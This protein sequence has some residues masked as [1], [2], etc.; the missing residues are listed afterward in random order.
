MDSHNKIITQVANN[1][2]SP[3]GFFQKGKS[4]TWLYDCGYCFVQVEFQ[5]SAYSRGSFCNVGIAFLFEYFGGLNETLAFDYGRERILV[6]NIQFVEYN[7]DDEIFEKQ[8]FQLAQ[9][10]LEYAEN[11]KRFKSLK[12]ANRCMS[13]LIF[14]KRLKEFL[15]KWN[16]SIFDYYNA[17]MIKFLVG[18]LKQ[19][20]RL[21]QKLHNLKLDGSL[22]NWAAYCYSEFCQNDITIESARE[23][24][25][26]MVNVR[27]KYFKQKGS[28]KKMP[29]LI[30]S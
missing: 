23:K 5:P 25:F 27:R 18:D 30:F 16:G 20:I 29:E 28:F 22:G 10:A 24:V 7:G 13:K 8:I 2:F 19:G 6:N 9:C 3:M 11:L 15:G 14:Q 1:V 4:R 12:Y 26:S 17:A 21:I